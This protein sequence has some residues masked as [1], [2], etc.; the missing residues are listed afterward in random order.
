MK[1]ILSF[2]LAATFL[3]STTTLSAFATYKL[4]TII[5]K[6]QGNQWCWVSTGTTIA[7]YYIKN[8]DFKNTFYENISQKGFFKRIK[9]YTKNDV[10]S[11]EDKKISGSMYDIC[12][13]L[14]KC[15]N[16]KGLKLNGSFQCV[17][18]TNQK[19]SNRPKYQKDQVD[20]YEI[21]PENL[22]FIKLGLVF[23]LVNIKIPN[24]TCAQYALEQA[25]V[26]KKS[27]LIAY[28]MLDGTKLNLAEI[29]QFG[30]LKYI[31][32][33]FSSSMKGLGHFIIVNGVDFK[34]NTVFIQD[35]ACG[36]KFT[37]T[38][39]QLKFNNG[40]IL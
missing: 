30:N 40:G 26:A 8:R 38:I 21:N 20:Q 10:I 2:I 5:E 31:N 11:E 24:K 17:E 29:D 34:T 39:D 35:P 3:I 25:I 22:P 28:C 13:G 32:G 37:M 27:P 7:N 14:F 15:F 9:G 1:K 33:G 16:N 18:C 36:K 23:N 12:D 19:L 4:D 6:Q